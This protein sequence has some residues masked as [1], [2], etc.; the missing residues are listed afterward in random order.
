[1]RCFASRS[2]TK[3]RLNVH[4]QPSWFPRLT[5]RT[6][7]WRQK[8]QSPLPLEEKTGMTRGFKSPN[9]S[10]AH[11]IVP[12]FRVQLRSSEK[13]FT[14]S[15]LLAGRRSR[16]LRSLRGCWANKSAYMRQIRFFQ[17]PAWIH[18]LHPNHSGVKRAHRRQRSL[19]W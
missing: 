4:G 13:C 14:R 6:V 8:S 5:K 11:P 18:N 19:S 9:D 7:D 12:R 17:P 10:T 15:Q 3:H 16:S 2:T 1:M